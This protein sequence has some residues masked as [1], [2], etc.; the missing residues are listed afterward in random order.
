MDL[1]APQQH[2]SEQAKWLYE[3]KTCGESLTYL[4]NHY[5]RIK[6]KHVVGFPTLKFNKVQTFLHNQ[7]MDQYKRTGFVRQIWSK[8]R[9]IGASTLASALT[10]QRCAFRDYHNAF[11]VSYDEDT[12]VERFD[13]LKTFYD[14]LPDPLKPVRR[15]DSRFKMEFQDRKSRMLAGHARNVN[16]GAG[17][18]NHIVHLT[19]AARYPNPYEVQ[20]S[21]FPTISDAR[22]ENPSIVI[23]ESTSYFGG[24]WFKDFAEA[25]QR[26]DTEYE[27]HFVP[28]HLHDLYRAQVP[29][30][31]KPTPEEEHLVTTKG[32]TY[33]NIVWR[34]KKIADYMATGNPM[35]FFQD[36][37]LD[38]HESWVLPKDTKR[39]FPDEMLV[40]LTDH[41]RPGKRHT[42]TSF[43][44]KD[45]IGGYLE[46][47]CE[48]QDGV[49]YDLGIDVA[50]GKDEKADWT[51]LEVLR[52]DTLEQCA[53]MRLHMDPASEEFLDLVYWTGMIY[54]RAQIIPDITG[55][56][57]HSLMNDL[58]RR[59]YPNLWQWRRRDDITERVS[60]RIG[61]H[62][63][64]KDRALLVTNGIRTLQR[65]A[66]IIHSAVLIQEMRDYIQIGDEEWSARPGAHDDTLQGWLLANQASYDERRGPSPPKLEVPKP[67]R[68]EWAYHDVD[69]DLNADVRETG[70]YIASLEAD[71]RN[72]R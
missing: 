20:A 11:L 48:P 43:G 10:F 59:S 72:W 18:M 14:A 44:L 62:Y 12:A 45:N 66:P 57:G 17:E 60:I 5:L 13:T 23:I 64:H 22:G 30:D 19:E 36:Y 47:W 67:D 34:R 8:S 26:G 16:V 9:Q 31:F 65:E 46:V 40:Y 61:F 54:N 25:A 50:G 21:L 56:W 51:V 7:I 68:P 53:E 2:T 39:V 15:Y 37:P 52:R 58:Q 35:G 38:W 33:G 1:T 49:F 42:P 6:S 63:T 69:A 4:C 28:W 55:G 29:R 41:I 70:E 3:A 71:E 32:L 24:D 27:F